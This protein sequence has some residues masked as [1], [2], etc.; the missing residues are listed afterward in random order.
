[1]LVHTSWAHHP[2]KYF[3]IKRRWNTFQ[4]IE[5]RSEGISLIRKRIY[6][7]IFVVI[8]DRRVIF[9]S[10]TRCSLDVQSQMRSATMRTLKL[11]RLDC[12]LFSWAHRLCTHQH[13]PE[14]SFRGENEEFPWS[15]HDDRR[16]FCEGGKKSPSSENKSQ[17]ETWPR[18][19]RLRTAS[20]DGLSFTHTKKKKGTLR[21]LILPSEHIS[22]AFGAQGRN[23]GW[24][25]VQKSFSKGP[26]LWMN[27]AR[28]V[29]HLA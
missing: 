1:M 20:E 25:V 16:D 23:S 19:H 3:Y 8:N 11:F 18:Q 2:E 9:M 29:L 13:W 27:T 4:E 24:G 12:N 5:S 26:D 22:E 7:A 14:T 28:V 17:T 10:D 15:C 6:I 21:P